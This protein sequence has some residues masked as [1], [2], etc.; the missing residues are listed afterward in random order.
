M[1]IIAVS[2]NKQGAFKT[3]GEAIEE[4]K[5]YSEEIVIELDE[6]TY[7]EKLEIRQS[8]ITI[9]GR[10]AAR[11]II[12]YNDYG[13][14]KMPDG[15]KRGTFRSQTMFLEGND[16][17]LENITIANT[18]GF[19]KEIGQAVALYADGSSHI[20]KNCRFVGHQ[21]TLFLAPLP[22]K[23]YEVNGFRGPKQ[24]APRTPGSYRLEHCYIEGTVDYIFGGGEAFFLQCE[25]KSLND[26]GTCYVTAASTPEEQ[27]Y[28]FVFYQCKFTGMTA[29]KNVYLGRP[30]RNY[31]KT[32]IIA[33]ELGECIAEVG[34]NDWGK[35]NAHQTITYA[36]A[37]NTG[38]G[39]IG[40]R[41]AYAKQLSAEEVAE[42]RKVIC[43]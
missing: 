37:E 8:H 4:A 6:G 32:V 17:T 40:K 1:K 12:E 5:K 7:H 13:F 25:L 10:D 15:E 29:E 43:G 34:W 41:A 42:Y 38:M 35:E 33:C 18:A 3:I 2:K 27:K 39:V 31:A 9:K 36:E 21:D 14:F 24:F 23:E 16:I 28:G 22:E 19:G 11:T 20:Y 30:W 26:K